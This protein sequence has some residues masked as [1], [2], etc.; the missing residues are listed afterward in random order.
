M[1]RTAD[2]DDPVDF[3]WIAEAGLAGIVCASGTIPAD[4]KIPVAAQ[5]NAMKLFLTVS[6]EGE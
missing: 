4:L 2:D 3:A 1:T 5:A 6:S